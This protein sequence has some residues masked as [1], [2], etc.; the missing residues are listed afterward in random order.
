MVRVR[1]GNLQDIISSI[2]F[3]KKKKKKKHPVATLD[4]LLQN[5]TQVGLDKIGCLTESRC[6]LTSL[7]DFAYQVVDLL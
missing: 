2:T 1:S 6:A 4:L 3:K 5:H 7:I